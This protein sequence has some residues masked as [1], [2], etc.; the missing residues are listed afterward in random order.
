MSRVSFLYEQAVIN[1]GKTY[2]FNCT[3]INV[4]EA[5]ADLVI[6]DIIDKLVF[7]DMNREEY[8]YRLNIVNEIEN[9]YVD[10]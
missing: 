1:A 10:S 5:L 7:N 6:Q 9:M 4:A 2:G 3:N 8:E